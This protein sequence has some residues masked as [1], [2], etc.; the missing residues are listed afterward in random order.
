MQFYISSPLNLLASRKGENGPRE[1]CF[2]DKELLS[3]SSLRIRESFLQ[4]CQRQSCSFVTTAYSV[5]SSI[6]DIKYVVLH[7]VSFSVIIFLLGFA[8]KKNKNDILT[9]INDTNFI[10]KR[11]QFMIKLFY[12]ACLHIYKVQSHRCLM[13]IHCAK[14]LSFFISIFHVCTCLFFFFFFF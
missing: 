9:I 10:F 14:L 6:S 8:E 7:R 2:S 5:A 11:Y 13:I 3:F 12:Y 1:R 4:L